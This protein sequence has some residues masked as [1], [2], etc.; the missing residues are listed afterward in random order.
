MDHQL[1]MSVAP[2][3]DK[4][5]VRNLKPDINEE[6]IQLHFESKRVSGS[7]DFDVIVEQYDQQN[8]SAIVRFSD[9]SGYL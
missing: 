3:N 7:E 4:I 8:C 1:V 2:E 5:L 6:T 9:T